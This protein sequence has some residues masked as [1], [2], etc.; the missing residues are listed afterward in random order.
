MTKKEKMTMTLP[1]LFNVLGERLNITL[2]DDLV[3]EKRQI[4]NEQ[5]ALVIGIA[6]QMIQDGDLI[7]RTEKLAAQNK[8]LTDSWSMKLITG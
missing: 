5:T 6:K 3:G 4:E 2:S 1:E 8:T 7:L